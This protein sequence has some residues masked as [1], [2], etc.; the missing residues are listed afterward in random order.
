VG[1]RSRETPSAA[2][3][4]AGR[5]RIAVVVSRYNLE[6]TKGLLRGALQV[7]EE[8]RASD[9][10]VVWVPGAIEIPVVVR[11]LAASGEVD[12]VVALGCVIKGETAHFEHVATQCASGLMRV[13]LDTGIPCAFG[14]LTTF[15]VEQARARSGDRDN[16]GAEAAETAIE[17]A[18]LVRRLG[19]E[20]AR[21]GGA[22]PAPSYGGLRPQL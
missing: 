3:L 8:R 14:V 12:A 18:N 11:R 19:G 5:L 13:S 1:E 2:D 9:P 4:D 21:D 15:D 6:I 16:K 22:P 20:E 17:T 10:Q 7:L